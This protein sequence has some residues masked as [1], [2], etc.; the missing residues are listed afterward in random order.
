VRTCSG[1]PTTKLAAC[2]TC[3]AVTLT[4]SCSSVSCLLSAAFTS[5]AAT[6]AAARPEASCCA[7]SSCMRS[8]EHVAARWSAS[9][10]RRQVAGHRVLACACNHMII[11]S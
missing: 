3:W 8:C 1:L 11:I 6:A 9:S 2:P 10:C 4:C 7:A 5:S